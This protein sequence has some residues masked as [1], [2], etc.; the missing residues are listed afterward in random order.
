MERDI[1]GDWQGTLK[2]S[3]A[4][5]RIV[6]RISNADGG[7]WKAAIYSIDQSASAIPVNAVSWDGSTLKFSVDAIRGGFEG[8]LTED[9]TCISGTWTQTR[10]VPL[11]LRLATSET[12]WPLDASPHQIRFV[13]VEPEVKLEVLDWGGSGRPVVL[14]AG[15]E[16]DAHI[17]DKFAPKLTPTYHVYAITR[18]GFGASSAPPSGYD[19]DRLGDDVIAVMDILGLR[20]PVLVGHSI[21]GEELSS[22][23]SRYPGKV[24]GLVYLDSAYG[25]A[26]YD[27]SQGWFDIDLVE[28]RRK[29]GQLQPGK[30]PADARNLIQE[31]LETDLPKLEKNLREKQKDLDA[32]PATLLAA[33]QK[34]AVSGAAQAV[35]A[36]EQKYTNIP[37][38]VLAI[39]AVPHDLGPMLPKGSAERAAYEARNQVTTEGQ[40]TAFEHGVPT[41]RVVRL[42]HASHYVFISHEP[43]VLREINAFVSSLPP[44]DP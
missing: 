43:D 12:A 15:L 8:A 23:A 10:P 20:Q 26:F 39:Y 35:F 17:Y 18:R 7:G 41:A 3:T 11:E 13:T 27:R 38:P 19:A 21:A 4:E 44:V 31:L 22:V 36:G 40:A 42:P 37:V 24:V 33:R 16:N 28:V 29:L 5:L 34:V 6:V 32:T 14:L 2:A 25:Y 9:G 30:G 1:T